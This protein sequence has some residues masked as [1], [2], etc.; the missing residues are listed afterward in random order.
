MAS[1]TSAPISATR[2]PS[3]RAHAALAPEPQL[4]PPRA[5]S[6]VASSAVSEGVP[7][8]APD[9][10]QRQQQQPVL[11]TVSTL[12]RSQQAARARRAREQAR[13]RVMRDGADPRGRLLCQLQGLHKQAISALCFSRD[14]RWLAL[15]SID[16]GA[17]VV[18]LG[19]AGVEEAGEAG[20]ARVAAQLRG[21][22]LGRM[23]PISAAAFSSDARW[24]ALGSTDGSAAIMERAGAT[25]S[26]SCAAEEGA[27]EW[28]LLTTVNMPSSSS[29]SSQPPPVSC[30]AFSPDGRWLALGS[31]RGRL[32]VV[33]VAAAAAAADT[34]TGVEWAVV[35]SARTGAG[36]CT[37]AFS[38]SG[39]LAGC[40]DGGSLRV[41]AGRPSTLLLLRPWRGEHG[42]GARHPAAAARWWLVVGG[43]TGARAA[44]PGG[45]GLCLVTRRPLAGAR[46][47]R[48]DCQR[49]GCAVAAR[50]RR[51]EGGGG[52]HRRGGGRGAGRGVGGCGAVRRPLRPFWRPF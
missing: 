7:P 5:S 1:D 12:E 11:Q 15:G 37:L 30:V 31:G 33:E 47:A 9:G 44:L 20:W 19:G 4:E 25:S 41:R 2:H 14:G 39:P 34:T 46:L 10:A 18:E 23:G 27:D 42:D 26:S 3:G 17:T 29:K 6:S 38:H 45:G 43:R 21:R 35:H 50:R 40:R 24:L 28:V 16:R 22:E 32:L 49:A 36:V 8:P 52:E 51:G 13:A 48:Q